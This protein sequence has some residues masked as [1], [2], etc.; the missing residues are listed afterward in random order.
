[1]AGLNT[2]AE[3]ARTGQLPVFEYV[4]GYYTK[5][6][7]QY[8]GWNQYLVRK[9]L[10]PERIRKVMAW[11]ESREEGYRRELRLRYYEFEYYQTQV[12]EVERTSEW[13]KAKARLDRKDE[14]RKKRG[15][16]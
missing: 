9:F 13:Q 6:D 10:R 3:L 11:R 12:E 16:M 14:R 7:L 2:A 5:F 8:R 1:M 4:E 15:G